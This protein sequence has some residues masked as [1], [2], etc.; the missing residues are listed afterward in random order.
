MTIIPKALI[1]AK[2]SSNSAIVDYTSTGVTTII[3][4][5]TATNVD[6]GA[7]TLSIWIVPSGGV[8][9][10][11]RQILKQLSFSAGE[12]KDLSELRN[13]IIMSGGVIYT[14]ASVAN[15]IVIRMSGRT[16]A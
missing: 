8:F 16:V 6:S 13:Q 1:E 10:T 4:K 15:A 3:D 2:Y 9:G 12:T 5:F 14:Q 7:Q 11:D